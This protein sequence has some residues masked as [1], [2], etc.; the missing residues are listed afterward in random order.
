MITKWTK[1][2]SRCAR[3]WTTLLGLTLLGAYLANGREIG[4]EDTEPTRLL[5]GAP[6]RG[7]GLYLDR[8]RLA[9]EG[10]GHG[11]PPYAT[12]SHGHWVSLYPVAPVQVLAAPITHGPP[13][14]LARSISSRAGTER[15]WLRA[16]RRCDSS[17]FATA[18]IDGCSAAWHSTRVLLRLGL[19]KVAPRSPCSRRGW[20]RPCGSLGVRPYGNT[21]RSRSALTVMIELLMADPLPPWRLVAAG[22]AAGGIVAFRFVDVVFAVAAFGF[23]A[24]HRPRGLPWFLP[25]PLLIGS[26]LV[27]YNFWS[28]GTLLGGLAQIEGV[29]SER[30]GVAGTWSGDLAS[31]A[32]S[33]HCSAQ[34]GGCSS[35][36]H[37]LRRWRFYS[38]LPTGGRSS[39][40][41][42]SCGCSG[43]SWPIFWCCRSTRSGGRVTA[44]DRDTGPRRFPC[45]RSCSPSRSTGAGP[46]A[47]RCFF[48]SPRQCVCGDLE[49]QAIGAFL[50]PSGWNATPHDVDIHHDGAS[51]TGATAQL[52]RC[53]FGR[54]G[55][56]GRVTRQC[57]VDDVR[58][59]HRP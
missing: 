58:S 13:L 7:D 31:G 1:P 49:A 11:A 21:A 19:A 55:V 18:A 52:T 4:N 8:F 41:R 51:G 6:T 3:V 46:I 40:G 9:F 34:R 20:P 59:K 2:T 16:T 25:A 32:A 53:L 22:A 27:A 14:V 48:P 57:Q 28:F 30:H 43:R 24:C 29:H 56:S 54:R 17:K 23:V 45:S 37:G 15:S 38:F 5:T 42:S 10:P 33:G 39:D 12:R 50:Y 35:S 44:L 36:L 47:A 26:A